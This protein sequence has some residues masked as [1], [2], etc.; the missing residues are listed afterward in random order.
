MKT[1]TTLMLCV[2]AVI[3]LAWATPAQAALVALWGFNAG[4]G[5]TAN[6]HS[7]NNNDGTLVAGGGGLP[8]WVTGHTG[9]AWDKALKFQGWTDRVRVLDSASFNTITNT[10]TIGLWA[11]ADYIASYQY[12]LLTSND[13]S[14]NSRRWLFQGDNGGGDQMYVWSDVDGNWK[15]GLGF[16][17][18]GGGNAYAWH[19]YAL[20]YSG[21][22]L[23][24]YV[25]GALKGTYAV[26]TNWP[27]FTDSLLI[28]GKNQ[29]WQSWEGPIDDVVIFNSVE[30]IGQIMAGTHPLM[31]EPATM[32]LMGLGGLGLL[33]GRKRR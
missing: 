24:A 17:I 28:G 13:S 11:K 12:L 15:K 23:T 6:D 20:Q 10:F 26:G 29:A 33:L 5:T 14:G 18:G 27:D 25:D 19:H 32:A 7:A 3:A 16:K 8:A 4:S 21:G 2:L 31:P 1:R 30:N 9:A 22:T